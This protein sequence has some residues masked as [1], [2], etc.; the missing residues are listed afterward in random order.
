MGTI[1]RP[2]FP[3]DL[4]GLFCLYLPNPTLKQCCLTSRTLRSFSRPLLFEHLTIQNS[5]H[6]N[7]PS[8]G[9]LNFWGALKSNPE[10]GGLVKSLK[11]LQAAIDR[12][13]HWLTTCEA[14]QR[15]LFIMTQLPKLTSF[16]ITRY[17]TP[18]CGS[19]QPWNIDELPGIT[20]AI[21]HILNLPTLRSFHFTE[22]YDFEEPNDLHQLFRLTKPSGLASLHLKGF[23]LEKIPTNSLIPPLHQAKIKNLRLYDIDRHP[24]R[25]LRMISYFIS[26]ASSFDISNLSSLDLCGI[27][28]DHDTWI[29]AILGAQKSNSTLEHLGLFHVEGRSIQHC[30]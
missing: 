4:L 17:G 15:L 25:G 10:I 5:V 3:G 23:E 24:D 30:F 7:G 14:N 16:S 9:D 6:E 1:S 21:Q 27:C 22:R 29:P 28:V 18:G 12:S 20:S 26:P 13:P 2:I 19:L 8:D 11:L